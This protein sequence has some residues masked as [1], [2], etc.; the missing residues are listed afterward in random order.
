MFTPETDREPLNQFTRLLL[1]NTPKGKVLDAGCGDGAAIKEFLGMGIEADGFDASEEVIAK[2]KQA[3]GSAPAKLWAAE[4]GLLTLPKES[5][6]G[7]WANRTLTK[8]TPVLAQRVVQTFFSALRSKGIL[9]VSFKLSES[10]W[11]EIEF[12]SMLRQSGFG[13]LWVGKP[14][15]ETDLVAMMAQRV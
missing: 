2:T 1:A 10:Q 6:D 14:V 13:A 15:G 3:L 4:L 9:F 5:Y 11:T 7:I 8:L 12:E